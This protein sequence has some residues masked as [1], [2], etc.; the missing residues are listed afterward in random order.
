MIVFPQMDLHINIVSVKIPTVF[1]A[2]IDELI[3]KFI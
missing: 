2:E 1:F 3:L